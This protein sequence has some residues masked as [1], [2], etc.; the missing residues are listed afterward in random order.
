[1][2]F[3]HLVLLRPLDMIFY[4][5]PWMLS[6]LWRYPKGL[7][8]YLFEWFLWECWKWTDFRLSSDCK[9]I[10]SAQ[11]WNRIRIQASIWKW[12]ENIFEG[13]H[14][15]NFGW[16]NVSFHTDWENLWFPHVFLIHRLSHWISQWVGILVAWKKHQSCLA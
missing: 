11:Y 4:K 15:F 3:T 12:L 1:M 2:S 6:N 7:E 10:L 5:I 16:P 9:Q 8:C 14:W 13:N